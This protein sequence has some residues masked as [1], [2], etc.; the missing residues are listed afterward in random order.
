MDTGKNIRDDLVYPE[1]SY[2][3]LGALFEVYNKLGNGHAEAVY[4][5]A[6]ADILHQ[7]KFTIKVF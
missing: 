3:V 2:Q 5:R 7:I 1:L 4:Q 6:V